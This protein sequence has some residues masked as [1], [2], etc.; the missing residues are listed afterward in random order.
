MEK[1]FNIKLTGLDLE[2]LIDGL[3]MRAESW[4][5][6]ADY[7]RTEKVSADDMFVIE[8]C[9]NPEEAENIANRYRSIINQIQSQMA[10]Q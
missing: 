3:E 1:I 4:E 8:E 7:L 2:Q 9:S 6:T 5:R 10:S